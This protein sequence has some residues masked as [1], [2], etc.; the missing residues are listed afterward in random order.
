MR[1][2]KFLCIS[3]LISLLSTSAFAQANWQGGSFT[4]M[5]SQKSVQY[6]EDGYVMLAGLMNTQGSVAPYTFEWRK[7]HE[8]GK[9]LATG[10]LQDPT[11]AKVRGEKNTTLTIKRPQTVCLV[12]YDSSTPPKRIIRTL[13]I[14]QYKN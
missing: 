1:L 12:V 10:K 4:P 3:A 14:E 8:D 2:L 5:L 11:P 6:T 13:E 9:L 7:E